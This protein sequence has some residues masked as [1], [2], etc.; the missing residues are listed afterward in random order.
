MTGMGIGSYLS[1]LLKKDLLLAYINI[2]ILLGFIGGISIPLL[3]LAFAYSKIFILVMIFFNLLIGTFIGFEIPILTRVLANNQQL[4][5]NLSNVL[6]LDYLGAL[7]ATL[8]FPFILLPLLGVYQTS[9]VFGLL[10]LLLGLITYFIFK[11]ELNNKKDKTLYIFT[12]I[13]A[14]LLVLGLYFSSTLRQFWDNKVYAYPVIHSERT[15]YQDLVL[16]SKNKMINL[17]L[18]GNL[19]FSSLDEYRYHESLVIIPAEN[20]FARS[21]VLV[22]G[23]GDGLAVRELLKYK[24][25]KSITLVD[26]DP[27]VTFLAKNNKF[28]KE[29]NQDSLNNERVK[30]VNE[31][32]FIYLQKNREQYDLIIADLPDPNNL[33]LGKLY[34]QQFYRFAYEN[35]NPTG[36]FVTQATNPIQAQKAFWCIYKTIA[37]SGFPTVYPFATYVPSFGQWGFVLASKNKKFTINNKITVA[38]KFLTEK[39][40]SSLFNLDKDIFLD[41]NHINISS[42]DKPKVVSYYL[43][44][45]EYWN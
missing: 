37:A 30:I 16:T 13:F 4:R 24:D 32:A 8:A 10:N 35:L 3:Y 43:D 39:K 20:C 6:S 1:R 28:L 26:L 21:K 11:G 29:C 18:N 38:T 22:L 19:Q 23:G 44:S 27:R 12:F 15:D 25:I 41:L 33:S 40:I 9:L 2:E 42:L 5:F 36:I 17:Y 14:L 31:D 45:W 7:I 34:T